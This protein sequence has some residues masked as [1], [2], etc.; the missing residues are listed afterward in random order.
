MVIDTEKIGKPAGEEK[1]KY[2]QEFFSVAMSRLDE[3][4]SNSLSTEVSLIP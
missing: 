1:Q 4:Y 3:L 2:H